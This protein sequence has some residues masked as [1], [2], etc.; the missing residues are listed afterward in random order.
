DTAGAGGA[1]GHRGR[2]RTGIC[3]GL[4]GLG[5][6]AR[7]AGGHRAAVGGGGGGG[8]GPGGGGGVRDGK[9]LAPKGGCGPGKEPAP[10]GGGQ[11]RRVYV[12]PS[13]WPV[14]STPGRWSCGRR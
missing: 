13:P 4:S 1:P 12:R 3:P 5:L 8:G 9:G 2:S 10:H 11:G 14:A 7:R 6:W